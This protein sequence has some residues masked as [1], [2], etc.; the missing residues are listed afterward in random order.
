MPPDSLAELQG[1]QMD[2]Q[3]ID[4][5]LRSQGL[6]V[7]SLTDGKRTVF[8]SLSATMVGLGCSSSFCVSG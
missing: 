2:E 7:L 5:F 3:E 6:G 4:Q 1:I 8:R